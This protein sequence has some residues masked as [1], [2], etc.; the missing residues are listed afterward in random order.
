MNTVDNSFFETPKGQSILKWLLDRGLTNKIIREAGI[1]WNGTHI[2]IPIKDIDGNVLFNKYRR[3]PERF[4]GPKYVYETGASAHL[5]MAEDLSVSQK[6]IICEGEFDCLALRSRGFIA[7]S[8][9]GGAG[10]FFEEWAALFTGKDVT[11]VF[12]NDA[13]GAKGS[14]RICRMIPHARF[15]R[16]PSSVGEHGDITDYFVKLGKTTEDFERLLA[17]GQQLPSEPEAPKKRP[18]K[19]I[20][21]THLAQAKLYPMWDLVGSK[22]NHSGKIRCPL[23]NESTPSFHIYPTNKWYCFG[24]GKGGDT[25]DFIVLKLGIPMSEAITV[26][27]NKF[28]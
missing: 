16:L 6:V 26:I 28:K 22:P 13:A 15:V 20:D 14:Y 27:L 18:V 8:S 9:T 3:D 7:V 21:G 23:H 19:K 11:V 17:F 4:T 5:Y 24:C 25:V 10:T 2:V 1:T 12:D